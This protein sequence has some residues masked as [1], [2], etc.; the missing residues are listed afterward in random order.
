MY[1]R[2]IG[3]GNLVIQA[4]KYYND[5]LSYIIK[6]L[7]YKVDIEQVFLQYINFINENIT[8]YDINKI[9][10]IIS[11]SRLIITILKFFITLDG[12]F[13]IN[14][15]WKLLKNLNI[16]K[17]DILE[18]FNPE[19]NK[20]SIIIGNPPWGLF[21][22]KNNV[23]IPEKFSVSNKQYDS[24]SLFLEYGIKN[25]DNNGILGFIIPNTILTNPNY[26]EIRKLLLKKSDILEIINLG[27]FFF[28]KVNQPAVLLIIHNTSKK[29]LF[30]FSNSI[31]LL[32]F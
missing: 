7:P 31:F 28:P 2:G 19:I 9:S 6:K 4:L 5:Y 10:L 22:K 21:L 15:Y 12:D 13:K 18:T 32:F 14:T 3:S 23:T 20:N 30:A 17:K 11:K 1:C 24:W 26:S 27:N 25:L 8:G 29:L 16:T